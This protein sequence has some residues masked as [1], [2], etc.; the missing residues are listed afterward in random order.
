MRRTAQAS[1]LAWTALGRLW[2]SSL[3]QAWLRLPLTGLGPR[4]AA[5]EPDADGGAVSPSPPHLLTG[6]L[7][8]VKLGGVY[9]LVFVAAA[10]SGAQGGLLLLKVGRHRGRSSPPSNADR[11][12]KVV[13]T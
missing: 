13:L 6:A 5:D 4:C 12:R 9:R 7:V 11:Y 3:D 8:R 2:S 1:S 10:Q